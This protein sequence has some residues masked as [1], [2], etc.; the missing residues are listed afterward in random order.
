MRIPNERGPLGLKGPKTGPKPPKPM[1]RKAPMQARAKEAKARGGK[2]PAA[3]PAY[4]AR[5]RQLPCIIC[6]K[7]GEQQ[8][9]QTAAHH[10]IHNRG[11]QRKTADDRAIPLCEGHHQGMIDK[12]KIALHHSPAAW[13][14]AYGEDTDYTEATRRAL[15]YQPKE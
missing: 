12:S 6:V 14:A 4:L 13:R 1:A 8:L 11:S 5:V 7:F 9:S 3:D 10:V 2:Q 15:N